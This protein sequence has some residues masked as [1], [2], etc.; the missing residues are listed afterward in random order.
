MGAHYRG[1]TTL[2]LIFGA[3]LA[4]ILS[5]SGS[6]RAEVMDFKVYSLGPACAICNGFLE[7][8]LRH[9]EGV[10]KV[11]TNLKSSTF[12]LL[13]SD[14]P[15]SIGAVKKA[16]KDSGYGYNYTEIRLKGVPID[17]GGKPAF[18]EPTTGQVFQLVE[19]EN[20]PIA[21]GKFQEM[22]TLSGNGQREIVIKAKA[23]P[24]EGMDQLQPI[25]MATAS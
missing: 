14:Q 3:V 2:G 12:N 20:A 15:I 6:S 8:K 4:L 10:S 19:G 22:Q 11:I 13:T 24:G 23:Y 7:A 17:A 18:K 1:K 25:E 21:S 9:V 16:V 5:Y